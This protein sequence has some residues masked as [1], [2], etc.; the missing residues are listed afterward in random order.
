MRPVSVRYT[1]ISVPVGCEVS[2]PPGEEDV[3]EDGVLACGHKVGQVGV[4]HHGGDAGVEEL[5]VK[6]GLRVGKGKRG[7]CF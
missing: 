3:V 6:Y 1:Y 7:N 5:E 2:V 4:G